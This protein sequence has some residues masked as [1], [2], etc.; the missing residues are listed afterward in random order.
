MNEITL[1][2][3]KRKHGAEHADEIFAEIARL[4]GFG[5]VGP[6]ESQL[7]PDAALDLRGV[8]DPDNKAISQSTQDKIK[9]LYDNGWPEDKK[10]PSDEPKP[11]A[12]AKTR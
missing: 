7:S 10:P 8:M 5:D 4:G 2:T 6:A 9:D 1:D 3:I 12:K 11:E